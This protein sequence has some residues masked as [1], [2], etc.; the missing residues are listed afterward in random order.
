MVSGVL[1]GRFQPFHLGHLSAVK[2]ALSKVDSLFIV[3]GSAEKSHQIQNP[4]TA[5]ERSRMIKDSLDESRINCHRWLTIPVPDG[6]TH[7]IW[8]RTIKDLVPRFEK[9][10]TNDRLT[11]LLFDEQKF[12]VI[13]APYLDRSQYS[14]TEIRMKMIK[15][16]EWKN[17]VT[18]S[19]A[20]II[21]EI[22][23]EQR[24]RNIIKNQRLK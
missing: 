24:L 12:E 4:F 8:I 10:F 7:S 14:G 9:V 1:I 17:F 23:G 5:G 19:V 11:K 13:E 16:G 3:I 22:N 15:D 18:K 20:N 21:K 6:K 2:F